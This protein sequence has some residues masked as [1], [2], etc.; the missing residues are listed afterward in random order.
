VIYDR[1]ARSR[2][3][4]TG[5]LLTSALSVALCA[6]AAAQDRTPSAADVALARS[7]GTEG[8]Q[9]ADAGNCPAAI[10][11][12]A[13][14]EALYH[15]PT[16]L[17][18]LGECQVAVGRVVAGTETLQRVVREPLPPNAPKAFV[19]AQERAK[20]SL[21]A[22]LPKLAKL[23]IHLEAPP[24]AQPIVRV[25]GESVPLATLDV[26]RPADPG[27]HVLDA[28]AA[29]CRAAV[30]EVTLQQGAGS[31]ATLRLDPEP[32]AA[33]SPPA[34]APMA[35][36]QPAAPPPAPAMAPAPAPAPYAPP[37]AAAP[38]PYAPQ[39]Q[40]GAVPPAGAPDTGQGQGSSATQTAGY[41][42]IGVGV[43]GLMVGSVFGLVAMGK[44]AT[45]D[46]QC[47]S[48]KNSCPPDAQS[49]IDS[50]KSAATG[51]TIGFAVGGVGLV[52]GIAL[53]IAGGAS[54][55]SEPVPA[56][57]VA[58]TPWIGPSSFGVTGVF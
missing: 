21:T 35:P 45:L 22:S 9:L 57:R 31:A 24:W 56:G 52:G 5:V 46:T 19:V 2:F 27:K 38:A 3:V 47:G 32:T 17:E 36:V 42:L 15:A 58:V 43:V 39:P 29:G 12:L 14:A 50:M 23:K 41:V 55:N 4:S 7:L 20:K 16:I 1:M 10:E 54:K 53:A 33:G 13:K 34:A 40:P 49:S 26:D 8:V 30:A 11:K 37:P 48:N 44:K 51:S 25:D 18:R 28:S 6:P